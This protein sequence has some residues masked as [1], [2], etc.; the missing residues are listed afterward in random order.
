MRTKQQELAQY[1][2]LTPSGFG[3]RVG[4]GAEHVRELIRSGT[5]FRAGEVINVALD[6]ARKTEYRIHPDALRRFLAERSVA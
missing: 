3:E 6:P 4:V 1:T 5:C 2:W